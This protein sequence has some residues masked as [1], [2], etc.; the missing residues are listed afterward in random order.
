MAQT[1]PGRW[2]SLLA[3]FTPRQLPL[4]L[5]TG[6]V[7]AMVN[8]L[9]SIALVSLIFSGDLRQVLPVGIGIGLVGSAVVAMVIALG[10]SFPGTYAGIQDASA[11]ILSLSAAAVV[12]AVTGPDRVETVLAMIAVTS[13]ATGLTFLAMGYFRWGEIARFVPFPVIGGLLAGTGFLI[14]V[15]ALEILGIGSVSALGSPGAAGLAWPGLLLVGLL[16]VTARRGWP[17][18]MYLVLLGSGIVVFHVATGLG[19]IDTANALSRG[20]LLGPI[21]TRGLWPGLATQSLAAADWSVIATQTASLASILVIAPISVLLYLS[22]VEI[23]TKRDLDLGADL[24]ATGWANVAAASVGGAPGYMYLADTVMTHRL[25]GPRRGAAVVAGLSI[26]GMVAVGGS[27]LEF[28]PQFVVGGILLFFGSEF[29]VEWL[30]V[31]RRKMNRLDYLLMV[32]IVI[33]IATVGFLEGVA[34]GL[35]AAIALF[36]VRYSRIDVVKHSLTARDHQSNI[37][38]PLHQSQLLREAG[39]SIL[40]LEL[41]GFIFFG[42]A[43]RVVARLR[44]FLEQTPRLRYVV[45]DFRLVTGVDSSALALFER[46]GLL[47]REHGFEV[48]LTDLTPTQGAQFAGLLSGYG[49]VVRQ[50]PDLDLGMAWC[51]DRLLQSVG[52]ETARPRPLP[53]GLE[54]Q[55]APYLVARSIRAGEQLMVEGDPPPGIFLLKQGRATVLLG[56]EDGAPGR[57]RT[58]LEGTVL[59]EISLYRHEPVTATV[60]A[61]TDCEVLHLTPETFADLCRNDP[62]TAAK[63]HIFVARTLAARVSHANSAI[64]ALRG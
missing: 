7:L 22:A 58:I 17:T 64:R 38:R 34:T 56:T 13:L 48:L 30:W 44:S 52:A 24:R 20:W 33:V 18:W 62:S 63:L 25:V 42:T 32:A 61:E 10:S 9:L 50:E 59:G 8:T 28:I 39:D 53:D 40:V 15:G 60:V 4:T 14:V 26:L 12:T 6:L 46:I 35:I 5:A 2:R 3:E 19:G 45:F 23:E 27:V 47:A 21:P 51:E 41:Q 36:V 11:A 57:L 55:L 37:E 49:D 29:L 16:F 31:A 1:R 54:T 43:G